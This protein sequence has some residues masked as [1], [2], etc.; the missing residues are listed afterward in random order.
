MN[1]ITDP[2]FADSDFEWLEVRNLVGS[3]ALDL[4]NAH[5]TLGISFTFNGENAISLA[6]GEHAIIAANP[7]AFAVR[8]GA[9]PHVVGPF[10]GD[11]DNSGERLVLVAATNESI[12]DFTYD[13]AW[14]PATDGTG[15]T[16][17][18]YDQTA[19]E[20]TYSTAN[21]WR[22]SAASRRIARRRRPAVL[23]PRCPQTTSPTSGSTQR[24][25]EC[26]RT[27]H[28]ARVVSSEPIGFA[29][30]SRGD[31]PAT[32]IGKRRY[33]TEPLTRFTVT[34]PKRQPASPLA[35]GT[36]CCSPP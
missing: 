3:A 36:K 17:V 5:F 8:Y 6:P 26:E 11:L 1:S 23:L 16:L 29:P 2:R 24:G 10:L 14:Y 20:A 19:P 28:H 27:S 25:G 15:P 7:Q 9:I 30:R 22:L 34:A 13:D 12:L 33:R 32:V 18:V 21:N 31:S 4:G 35:R